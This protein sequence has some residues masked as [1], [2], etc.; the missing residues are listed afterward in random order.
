MG[1][2]NNPRKMPNATINR[3]VDYIQTHFFFEIIHKKGK[4]FGPDGLSRRKWYLGDPQEE[5]F[6]DGTD[7]GTGDI[8]MRKEDPTSSDLLELEEFYEEI[9]SREKFFY[10][11]IEKGSLLELEKGLVEDGSRDSTNKIGDIFLETASEEPKQ[12]LENG[13]KEYDDNRRSNHAKRIDERIKQIRELLA[14]KS[15]RSFEKLTAE[16]ASLIRAASHYWLD[17]E[18][19]RLYKKNARNNSLQ[20]VMA[21]EDRMRLLKSCHDEI[22]HQGGYATNKLLQQRFW[23]P[24]IEEDAVWYVRTCHI[25]QVRQRRALEL[26]SVVTHTLSIFQVLHADTVHMNLPSNGCKYIVHGRCRLLSWIEAKA[27]KEENARSIGQW[28]FEDIICRW[29]S[30]VKIVTDNRAPFKKAMKWLEEKYRI[31]GVAIS[32]YNSQAN[33]IVKRLHWDLRQILY[34]ATKGDVRK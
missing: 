33:S 4:T 21:E 23:W 32:P 18:D 28:L 29:G 11:S 1:M 26:L 5:D 25:C 19:G 34:K 7:D 31:K 12:D 30:L 10:E 3:W 14:T 20:L 6:K 13:Q 22:G 16:Q 17:K 15:K 8:V 9:N 24:E 27:L 2:L